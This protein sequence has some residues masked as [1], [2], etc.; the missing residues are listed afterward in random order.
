[1]VV[2]NRQLV[3]LVR[4]LRDLPGQE[5]F[6]YLDEAGGRHAIGSADVNDYLRQASDEE[7]TA[8][9]FRTWAGTYLSVMA[10]ARQPAGDTDAA[11]KRAM[12]RA[13]EQVSAALGNTPAICRKCYIHPTVLDGHMTGTLAPRF[14][15][16]LDRFAAR[17]H[18][19]LSAE[20]AAV[21][22]LLEEA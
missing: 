1:M 11:R 22:A 14:Q 6:Q 8:K 20:E 19:G 15:V 18:D 10:L 5:L 4:R 21:M 9:N 2:R 12:L 17:P 7:I 3:A 13:I 16:L